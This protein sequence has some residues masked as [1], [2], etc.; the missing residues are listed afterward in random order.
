MRLANFVH[1][2]VSILLI[3]EQLDKVLLEITL[4]G[5]KDLLSEVPLVSR[6]WNETILVSDEVVDSPGLNKSGAI[7]ELNH[8]QLS[9]LKHVV[10]F[11]LLDLSHVIDPDVLELDLSFV[12]HHPDGLCPSVS[13]EVIEFAS[14][15]FSTGLL[16]V[17]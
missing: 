10:V 11:H 14:G 7:F 3:S 2:F 6:L 9:I 8:G 1:Y 16:W 5:F 17:Q 15:E 13:I 12:E 4:K